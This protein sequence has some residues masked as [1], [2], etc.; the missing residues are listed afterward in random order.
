MAV[1]LDEMTLAKLA[2]EL[3]KNIRDY[4]LVFKDF[5]ITEDDYSVIETNEFYKKVKEHFTVE[6][7]SANST[8]DRIRLKGAAGVETI[9][10]AVAKRAIQP[11][12]PLA[13]VIEGAKFMAK[14][15]GIGEDRG[16][17][18]NNERFVITINL[19]AD[20]EVFNKSVEI[21][22]NDVNLGAK[23]G[24][25]IDAVAEIS[26]IEFLRA[27]GERQRSERK[28]VRELPDS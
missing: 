21:N 27:A 18:K 4:K 12:E 14:V 19:G 9:M 11:T 25:T 20:T 6:W 5:G 22:P 23:H 17:Q 10:T 2:S 7:N 3:V 8:A 13:S 16:E 1:D 24:K 28:G 15:A 26:T